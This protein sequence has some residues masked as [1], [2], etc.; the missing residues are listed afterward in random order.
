MPVP[1]SRDQP[2]RVVPPGGGRGD[3]SVM[4]STVPVFRITRLFVLLAVVI[5]ALRC[6]PSP[7][8]STTARHA[9]NAEMQ[10]IVD[11]DQADREP[12]LNTLDWAALAERDAARR[13]RVRA[14]LDAGALRTGRDFAKAALVFQHGS[15]SNDILL[16]HVLAMTAV[17][18]GHAESRRLAALTL[19]RYLQQIGE[20]QVFGTQFL[21]TDGNDPTK[22]SMEP[23]DDA[24]I[25]DALR[26]INCV[27]SRDVSERLLARLKTG[28][29]SAPRPVCPKEGE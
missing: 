2:P 27:E 19:D 7:P 8:A 1:V 16:A 29:V 23:Y 3:V 26:A 10:T 4:M 12:D 22:W 25:P 11:A 5:A 17:A 21:T 20:S 9:D 28:D 24:L 14:L 6:A 15:T 18:E 13:E